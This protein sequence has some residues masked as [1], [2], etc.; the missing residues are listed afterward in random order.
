MDLSAHAAQFTTGFVKVGRGCVQEQRIRGTRPACAPCMKSQWPAAKASQPIQTD[1]LVPPARPACAR[2]FGVATSFQA[3]AL[4][5]LSRTPG[6]ARP[7]HVTQHFSRQVQDMSYVVVRHPEIDGHRS[8]HVQLGRHG[9]L[10]LFASCES[11]IEAMCRAQH[12]VCSFS[13]NSCRAAPAASM[14]EVRPSALEIPAHASLAPAFLISLSW[15]AVHCREF[16]QPIHAFIVSLSCAVHPIFLKR[17]LM[18]GF[19]CARRP[20]HY[21][22]REG[23]ER[24]RPGAANSRNSARLCPMH[25]I[26]VACSQGV[27]THSDGWSG[28]TCKTCVRPPLWSCDVLPGTGPGLLVKDTW[29]CPAAS[30]DAALLASGSGYVVCRSQTPGNRWT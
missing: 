22:L 26:S 13:E 18:H 19:E 7:R 23:R 28:T 11:C 17:D 6:L 1:G 10:L 21:W 2:P 25:E 3:Q 16:L 15:Q 30:C 9:Q 27:P 12:K 4:A 8:P 5:C 14:S 29:A 24:L 20:I